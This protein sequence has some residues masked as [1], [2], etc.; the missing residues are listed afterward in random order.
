MLKGEGTTS[1]SPL[2]T[3][4]LMSSLQNKP[5][6]SPRLSLQQAQT[7]QHSHGHRQILNQAP[8]ASPPLVS[9]TTSGSL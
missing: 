1:Y 2:D 3:Q 6:L 4:Y 8:L 7:S 9:S 5:L